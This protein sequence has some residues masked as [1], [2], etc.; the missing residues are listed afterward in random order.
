MGYAPALEFTEL[1]LQ[2]LLTSSPRDGSSA[3]QCLNLVHGLGQRPQTQ[4]LIHFE[5][6]VCVSQLTG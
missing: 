4:D 1:A 6:K 5:Q 3:V 2:Q